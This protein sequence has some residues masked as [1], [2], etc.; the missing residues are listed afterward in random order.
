VLFPG[1][2]ISGERPPLAHLLGDQRA[3]FRRMVRLTP[4][5]R[6]DVERVFRRGMDWVLQAGTPKLDEVTRAFGGHLGGGLES[7][8]AFLPSRLY[9]N[10]I[11][12][13]IEIEFEPAAKIGP[14]RVRM[15]PDES[16]KDAK[17]VHPITYAAHLADI[18][19]GKVMKELK[20]FAETGSAGGKITYRIPQVAEVE[21]N[22]SIFATSPSAS[23][24]PIKD[25]P[26]E[27]QRKVRYHA[28]GLANDQGPGYK[29][30]PQKLKADT[31]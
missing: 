29:P 25:L 30:P 1:S 26:E 14:S 16:M 8:L 5:E 21:I 11:P 3:P 7:N 23:P 12:V 31:N 13:E 27:F 18:K 17:M 20:W 10:G 9:P 4:D 24:K 15:S 19:A 22:A 6:L 2:E 28:T